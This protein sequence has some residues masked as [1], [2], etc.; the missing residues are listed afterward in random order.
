MAKPQHEEKKLPPVVQ[1]P[2]F[3][4]GGSGTEN[5]EN[6]IMKR[7][8]VFTSLTYYPNVGWEDTL[9]EEG[10]TEYGR[11]RSFDTEAEAREAAKNSGFEGGEIQ[12]VD[13][14]EGRVVAQYQVDWNG[15]IEV[16]L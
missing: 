14:H 13:L 8:V 5:R 4:G 2:L 7:F 15:G 6:L 1:R 11:A 16:I 9:K 12:I 10:E 3:Q